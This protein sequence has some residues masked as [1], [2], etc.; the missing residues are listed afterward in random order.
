MVMLFI[1]GNP[2]ECVWEWGGGMEIWSTVKYTF[3]MLTEVLVGGLPVE[4][5]SVQH[6]TCVD[7]GGLHPQ[8]PPPPPPC[9]G[10]HG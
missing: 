7:V 8:A 6:I 10:H 9:P 1:E 4:V 2:E 5:D 3:D